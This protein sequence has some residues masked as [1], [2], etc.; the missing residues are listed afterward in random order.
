MK[1]S[2]IPGILVETAAAGAT[3]F[4]LPVCFG[5]RSA[6]TQRPAAAV[7]T[8]I[9]SSYVF[10]RLTGAYSGMRQESILR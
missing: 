2:W 6:S 10:R 7:T 9:P 8:R 4:L 1:F 5:A 3:N